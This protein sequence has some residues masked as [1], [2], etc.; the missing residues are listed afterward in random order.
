MHERRAAL[1]LATEAKLYRDPG[2]AEKAAHGESPIGENNHAL[3]ALR[4][5]DSRLAS[6]LSCAARRRR[7]G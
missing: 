4:Y 6:S 3:G 1:N 2:A 5:L 7:R